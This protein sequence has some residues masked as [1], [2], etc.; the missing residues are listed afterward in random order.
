MYGGLATIR[1]NGRGSGTRESGSYRFPC[2]TL[3]RSA[4]LSCSMFRRATATAAALMSLASTVAFFS[5]CAI[6]AAMHPL[7]VH[8]SST[9]GA[10]NPAAL[11]QN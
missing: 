4:S 5:C 6:A 7:P 11:R 1:S 10:S 2:S 8:R 9:R 3:T